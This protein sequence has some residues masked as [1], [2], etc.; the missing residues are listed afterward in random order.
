[1]QA[2][3]AAHGFTLI[4]VMVVAVVLGLL[5]AIAL[6]LYQE[7]TRK[8]RRAEAMRELMELALRQER[9]HA[10]H[11]AYTDEIA[12][13]AGL[14]WRSHFTTN[15]RY[16]LAASSCA[17]EDDLDHCYV[18]EAEPVGDQSEDKCGRLSIAANGARGA[19]GAIGD[20]CW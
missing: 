13:A 3:Q 5:T 11:S 14:N 9:F 1:M 4:E 16:R 10:Q 20:A 19:S 2:R 8:S 18:L 17:D 15:E 6:P 12:G 7:T